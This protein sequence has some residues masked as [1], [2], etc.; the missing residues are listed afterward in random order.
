MAKN[1]GLTEEMQQ[2]VI[3]TVDVSRKTPKG[4]KKT[5]CLLFL[6]PQKQSVY[7]LIYGKKINKHKAFLVFSAEEFLNALK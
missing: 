7:F 5:R 4:I 1:M 3:G 6:D 2:H